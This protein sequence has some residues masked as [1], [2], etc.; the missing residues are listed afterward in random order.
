MGTEGAET[1]R[2]TSRSLQRAVDLSRHSGLGLETAHR[3]TA[4]SH[5]ARRGCRGWHS[6]NSGQRG[7]EMVQVAHDG[8]FVGGG[9]GVGEQRVGAPGQGLHGLGHGEAG[10]QGAECTHLTH[11]VTRTRTGRRP[12]PSGRAQPRRTAGRRDTLAACPYLPRVAEP[13]R[14]PATRRH[15]RPTSSRWRRRWLAR[16]TR[17]YPQGRPRNQSALSRKESAERSHSGNLSQHLPTSFNPA[18]LQVIALLDAILQGNERC[19]S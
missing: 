1:G 16:R 4:P 3:S 10:W 8:I 2:L 15:H 17:R 19:R 13:V 6:G 14:P 5:L 18:Y 7:G 11:Y 9:G 12:R